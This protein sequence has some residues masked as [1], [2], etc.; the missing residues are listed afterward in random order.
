MEEAAQRLPLHV[1]HD[2]E[3]EIAFAPELVD[4][5]DVAVSHGSGEPGLVENMRRRS[6][7]RAR[8]AG[9][10]LMAMSTIPIIDG[11]AITLSDGISVSGPAES[12]VNWSRCRFRV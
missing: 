12:R 11:A 3:V 5:D 2:D 4:L 9:R 7:S 6:A 8:S 1:F 10:T